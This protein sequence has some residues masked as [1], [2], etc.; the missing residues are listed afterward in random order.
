YA[1]NAKASQ[2][3]AHC[4]VRAR[5]AAWHNYLGAVGVVVGGVSGHGLEVEEQRSGRCLD[6]AVDL[7]QRVG[8]VKAITFVCEVGSLGFWIEDLANPGRLEDP[9][10]AQEIAQHR[11]EHDVAI[12]APRERLR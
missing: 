7:G 5:S 9:A 8:V 1:S 4:R 2:I 3:F 10:R 6:V 12:A 11:I